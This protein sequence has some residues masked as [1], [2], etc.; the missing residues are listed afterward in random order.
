MHSEQ[1][2]KLRSYVYHMW[3]ILP[4]ASQ[5]L[6]HMTSTEKPATWLEHASG[7]LDREYICMPVGECKPCPEDHVRDDCY[8]DHGFSWRT[9]TVDP[10]TIDNLWNVCTQLQGPK[11]Q[12]GVLVESL[13]M[14]KCISIHSMWYV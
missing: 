10:T 9:R 8:T 4:R 12:D 1:P 11:Y 7:A 5:N 13:Y 6:F 14:Q 3:R 2:P